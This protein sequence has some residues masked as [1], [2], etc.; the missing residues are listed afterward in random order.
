MD[1]DGLAGSKRKMGSCLVVAGAISKTRMDIKEIREYRGATPKILAACDNMEA[2][3][4]KIGRG[5]VENRDLCPFYYNPPKDRDCI[6]EGCPMSA[7]SLIALSNQCS[8]GLLKALCKLEAVLA[9]TDE[10]PAH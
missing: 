4:W 3:L 8:A 5:I 7:S 1:R 9:E 6:V 10:K 2:D